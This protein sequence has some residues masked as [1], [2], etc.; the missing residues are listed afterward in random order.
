MRLPMVLVK[1]TE[2]LVISRGLNGGIRIGECIKVRVLRISQRRVTLGVDSP[3]EMAVT[4][5]EQA[6]PAQP[7]QEPALDTRILMVEDT[8]VHALLIERFLTHQG[9]KDV[10]RTSTGEDALRFLSVAR[11]TKEKLPDLVLLDLILPGIS[12]LEVIKGIRSNFGYKVP[13]V[14]LTASHDLYEEAMAA[15][16]N[17][18]I[19]KSERYD[20]F[21]RQ[22]LSV[23]DFW[24]KA[25]GPP[26]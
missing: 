12:G 24:C 20:E 3:P 26:R 18:Y 17:A 15:G 5:E 23:V 21:R 2:M 9:V 14:V 13:V 16:A 10:I 11:N 19:Q 7:P 6:P 4:R 8:P 22:I 25:H 1:G